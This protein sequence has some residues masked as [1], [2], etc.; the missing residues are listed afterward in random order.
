[1]TTRTKRAWRKANS[2]VRSGQH[3]KAAYWL[4]R[5]LAMLDGDR[6]PPRRSKYMETDY[7][8]AALFMLVMVFRSVSCG[9]PVRDLRP[10]YIIWTREGSRGLQA[11]STAWPAHCGAGR[12]V[13]SIASIPPSPRYVRLCS[14]E[15]TRSRGSALRAKAGAS[16]TVCSDRVN[17]VR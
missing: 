11:G 5:T 15:R 3:A 13:G 14:I 17:R 7:L 1:M 6:A 9:S 4:S 12:Q 10:R 16:S 8:L 2:Y